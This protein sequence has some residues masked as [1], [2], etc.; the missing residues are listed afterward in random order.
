MILRD[1]SRLLPAR[2]N[3]W[4][5]VSGWGDEDHQLPDLAP[6]DM[7]LLQG[8]RAFCL[9]NGFKAP[10]GFY[11]VSHKAIK[12]RLLSI[13]DAD[14]ATLAEERYK[15]GAIVWIYVC[16]A[17]A[18]HSHMR[19][20]ALENDQTDEGQEII[21]CSMLLK[22]IFSLFGNPKHL[23]WSN[24]VRTLQRFWLPAG[25]EA[26]WKDCWNEGIREWRGQTNDG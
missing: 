6:M 22:R 24:I 20:V 2:R 3:R 15:R 13:S 16:V 14:L 25:V 21:K 26:D 4:L 19:N 9:Q 1:I 10:P 17:G 23:W 5:K 7:L 12:D 18:L 11:W 8:L